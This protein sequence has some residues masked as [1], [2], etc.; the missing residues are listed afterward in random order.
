MDII[1]KD[2]KQGEISLRVTEEEDLWHLSH[3][4][5]PQDL[6]RGQTE[7]KIKIGSEENF[8]VV[9][10]KV[11]LKLEAEKTEYVPENNSLRILGTIKEGPDDVPLGSY[12]SF[13]V[14]LNDVITI[15][16]E[17]WSNYQIKRLQEAE[18]PRKKSLLVVFDR[19]EAIIGLLTNKGFQKLAELKGDV[20][21][22]AD[23][24]EGKGN[25]FKEIARNIEEYKERLKTERIILG[26]PAFWKEYVL[27]EL[28][29]ET[30]KKTMTSTV[31]NV[32]ENSIKE[33]LKSPSL[34]KAL[35]DDRT[36]RE[37]KNIEEL[38]KAISEDKAFYGIKEATDKINLGAAA[39][40]IVSEKFL[41]DARDEGAYKETDNLLRIAESTNAE[42]I[43]ITQKEPTTKIDGLGGIAGILRWKT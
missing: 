18:V 35:E 40:V 37:E 36:A 16:K 26:S 17:S 22:K 2:F 38:M 9:R 32:S 11:Y 27:K 12:H 29:D 5:E 19:E 25:F 41:K 42:V 43:I 6:V 39:K 13:N 1:K 24:T 3:I 23:N 33:L 7:R 4:V 28:L 34:G 15:K 14:E 8:K 30:K 20:Q 10:K 31:S 21:K